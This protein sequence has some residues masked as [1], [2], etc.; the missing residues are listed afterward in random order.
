MHMLVLEIIELLSAGA[1]STIIV[2]RR[3]YHVVLF[4][5]VVEKQD[6]RTDFFDSKNIKGQGQLIRSVPTV[7]PHVHKYLK[8]INIL[9]LML[10]QSSL[11]LSYPHKFRQLISF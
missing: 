11:T 4:Q 8:A 1:L 6:C 10:I 5:C 9:P 2:A 3:A 7:R